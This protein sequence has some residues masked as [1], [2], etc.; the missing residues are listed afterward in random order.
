[1]SGDFLSPAP[2]AARGKT[3]LMVDDDDLVRMLVTA[4]LTDLGYKMLE[5]A[6]GKA[7][8]SMMESGQKLDLLLTDIGLPGSMN[9]WQLADAMRAL[10][11]GLPVLFITG[12]NEAP[13][14]KNAQLETGMAVI[15]K[16][17]HM[18]TLTS[19]IRRIIARS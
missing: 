1:M 12:Y 5:A 14:G 19:E 10:R 8:M 11:P 3:I 7:A 2:D 18:K 6:N 9:G 13:E 17:F 15:A 16:P 4:S